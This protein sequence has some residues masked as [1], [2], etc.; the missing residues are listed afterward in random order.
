MTK[1]PV[2]DPQLPRQ[3]LVVEDEARLR[4]MLLRAITDMG[5]EPIGVASGEEAVQQ[6]QANPCPVSIL[7]LNLPGMSGL[8]LLES[9]RKTWPRT[10]AI[11]LTGFGDLDAARKAIHLDVID[12]LTKPCTLGDLEVSLD[13]AWR[14][15]LQD[16]AN[17]VLKP[18][19]AKLGQSQP[20]SEQTQHAPPKATS[21][22]D[23]ERL[24]ILRALERNQGNRTAAA[25][26][27]GISVRKLYYRLA[28][29]ER[30]GLLD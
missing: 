27:L 2:I 28:E 14:R 21:L 8:E 26:E 30:K 12:F 17:P 24:H 13:R 4:Q 5:F 16:L 19:L 18:A 29:Y 22:E 11:I 1:R 25:A 15:A 3:V 20:P 10:Q 23:L 6:M 7:D 9:I